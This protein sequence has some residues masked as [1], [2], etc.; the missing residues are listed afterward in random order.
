M[1]KVYVSVYGTLK[2][3]FGA[4]FKL[5]DSEMI[6][7]GFHSLPFQMVS[8][9]AF[10][11]LIP[12]EDKLNDIYLETY[13]ISDNSMSIMEVLDRYE[14]YPDFY[15]RKKIELGLGA[16]SWVYFMKDK[17]GRVNDGLIVKSG[18]WE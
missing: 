10:P 2:R 13:D 9:G 15:D 6:D 4:N 7:A 5:R 14:G 18:K 3:G 11:A 1:S 8:L 16:M 12:S 17:P